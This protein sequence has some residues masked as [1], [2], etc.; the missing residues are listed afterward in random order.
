MKIDSVDNFVAAKVPAENREIVAAIRAFMRERAP[1]A[2]E[3]YSYKMPVWKVKS[4]VAFVGSVSPDV[5]LG[6]PH[7]TLFE[8][9]YKLL[10]GRGRVSR[11][12][13]FKTI[14]DVKRTALAYYLKQSLK[15]DAK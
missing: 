6:F 12:L 15:L 2:V 9:K 4:I 3:T 14:D 13:R 1:Q 11:H 7:G 5:T 8:D 10:Q